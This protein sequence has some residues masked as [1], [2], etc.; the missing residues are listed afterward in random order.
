MIQTYNRDMLV[1]VLPFTRQYEGEEVI[2]GRVETGTFLAVPPGAVEVL[3]ALADGKSVGE[4]AD[5]YREKHGEVPDL[6][7]FLAILESKG[8]VKPAGSDES[9]SSL[10]ASRNGVRE[11]ARRAPRPMRYH[12][13]NFP[14]DVAQRIFSGPAI[15][16]CFGLIAI[17]IA[18][19][20]RDWSLM[21]GP[22][23]L[24]FTD[25]RILIWTLLV[26][27]SYCSVVLHELAHMI[28]AR[29]IGV[30]SRLG[31]GNRLFDL[32]VETDLSGLWSV[33]KRQRYLPLLAG[34]LLD[35]TLGALVVMLLYAHS[36]RWIGLSPIALRVWRGLLFTYVTRVFWQWFLFVRTDYYYVIATWLNCRNLMGDTEN[37]LRNQMAIVFPWMRKVDQSGIPA[38]ER[39]V[40]P[41]YA[42][43]WIVGRIVAMYWFFSVTIPLA[44]RY[45]VDL[46]HSLARFSA[47]PS[48][49]W[50][51]L[52]LVFYFVVPI[53]IGVPIWLRSIAR[54]W[55]GYQAA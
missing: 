42:V 7:D 10:A 24:F 29:A 11:D 36:V 35:A 53:A 48:D 12:F 40:I 51:S 49:F 33:P 26:F 44:S 32:V 23:D 18:L 16:F 46:G 47:N 14:Q 8:I 25:H 52:L 21:P 31:F 38:A 4:A 30:N 6:T 37:F 27:A 19:L 39:R 45:I 43:V 9:Q 41:G 15:G 20:I 55:L 5:L 34:C 54:R 3:E 22:R 1:D 2:I 17:G 13:S 50:D 28:S